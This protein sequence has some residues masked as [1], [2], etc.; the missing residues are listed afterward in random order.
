[1]TQLEAAVKMLESQMNDPANASDATLFT[2][3]ASMSKQLETAMSEWEKAEEE[4]ER[5]NAEN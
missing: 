1:M 3:H 4:L 5:F 2:R